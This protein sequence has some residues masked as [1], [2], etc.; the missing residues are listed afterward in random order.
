MMVDLVLLDPICRNVAFEFL[1]SPDAICGNT[2][3]DVLFLQNKKNSSN[4]KTKSQKYT[5]KQENQFTNT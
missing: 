1:C 3:K 5:N 2:G 4:E